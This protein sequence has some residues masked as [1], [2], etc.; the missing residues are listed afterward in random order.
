MKSI[1]RKYTP[2]TQANFITTFKERKRYLE[3]EKA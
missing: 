2:L 3:D 1:Y